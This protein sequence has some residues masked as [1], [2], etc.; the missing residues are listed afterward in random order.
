M[1]FRLPFFKPRSSETA[2]P[3][4]AESLELMRKRSRHRL[5]GAAVLVLLGVI[6]FPLLFDT[7]PRPIPVDIAIDIPDKNTVKP[8][9]VPAD[10]AARPQVAG[11]VGSGPR[12]GQAPGYS[13][14]G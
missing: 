3:N 5:I 9:V 4:P 10:T 1:S 12:A 8:L 2:A 13:R 7:Q 14:H 11:P 6:G